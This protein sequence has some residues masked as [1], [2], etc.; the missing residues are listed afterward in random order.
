M[1]FIIETGVAASAAAIS[2]LLKEW[3]SLRE[4]KKED[5]LRAPEWQ[6]LEQAY[7]AHLLWRF[8]YP[9]QVFGQQIIANWIITAVVL[10]LVLS[11][12]VFSFIQLNYALT[13]GDLTSLK[14]SREVE[15][16]GKVSISSSIVGAITLVISLAFFALYLKYVFQ[17]KHP[18]PPHVS[19]SE[20]DASTVLAALAAGKGKA[21]DEEIKVVSIH[22]G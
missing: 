22:A 8:Q 13:L 9:K 7:I 18:V 5:E 17:I 1:S 10:V 3:T 16:A 15:T 19:I 11:G 2:Q 21:K 12:L 20:T 6:A 4:T 14:T